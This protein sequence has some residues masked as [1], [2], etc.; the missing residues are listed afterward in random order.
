[1]EIHVL[2]GWNTIKEQW[3]FFNSYTPP[4]WER[5][6]KSDQKALM[7]LNVKTKVEVRRK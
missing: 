2:Y 6:G 3:V 5:N 7:A 4:E 1:M